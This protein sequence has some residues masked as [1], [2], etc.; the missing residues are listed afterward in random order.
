MPGQGVQHIPLRIP[1]TWDA[2]WFA[3]FIREVLAL[4]DIRNAEGDGVEISGQSDEVATIS[5]SEDIANLLEQ[6]YILATP[7]GFLEFERTL[8]EGDAIELVDSGAGGTITIGVPDRGVNLG[9]LAELSSMGVLGNPVDG[10]GAI[11]NVQAEVDKAVL[12]RSGTDMLFDLIDH[13]YVSDW[14]EATQDTVGA[15]LLDSSSINFTYDDTLGVFTADIID[16]YVQ[17]LVGA[18]LADS[19]SVDFTYNDGAGTFTASTINANPTGTIG[20]TAVNGT[21]ATPMRS[22]AAPALSQAISPT[23]T[24]DH[25]FTDGFAWSSVQPEAFWIETD[26]AANGGVWGS[27]V[28]GGSWRLSAFSDDLATEVPALTF[29]RSG[30]TLGTMTIGGAGYTGLAVSLLTDNVTPLTVNGTNNGSYSL[31]FDNDS[32]GS[33]NACRIVFNSGDASG[34]FFTAGSG[35]TTAVL[36]GG[37]TGAQGVIRMLGAYPLILGTDNTARFQIPADGGMAIVD[38]ITAPAT[39]SGWAKIYVDSAD[40]DLKVKFGDGTVKTIVT[41]T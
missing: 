7:S 9:K 37:P 25:I 18:M 14:D 3:D 4:A 34:A 27:L 40:G 13:T 15:M 24:G 22:D 32:N 8:A 1:E 33:A 30:T 19:T 5:V 29:A 16:E 39:L 38:G 2:K 35:R 20:L 26:A 36:T 11:Q 10:A 17:D 12:H 21:A 28:A 23:W 31:I 41:D 6:T